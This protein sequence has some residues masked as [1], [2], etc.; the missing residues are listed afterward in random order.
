MNKKQAYNKLV[1]IAED[2]NP[3]LGGKAIWVKSNPPELSELWYMIGDANGENF[4]LKVAH[5]IIPH[6]AW[7]E[8]SEALQRIY[9][10][11]EIVGHSFDLD[12]Y[13]IGVKRLSTEDKAESEEIVQMY[14]SKEAYLLQLKAQINEDNI[15]EIAALVEIIPG[16][17]DDV[18]RELME[19]SV[20]EKITTLIYETS[21][22]A[23]KKAAMEF[24]TLSMKE[25][26]NIRDNCLDESRNAASYLNKLIP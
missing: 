8:I 21:I 1:S 20:Q 3:D 16:L 6:D 15:E 5:E 4:S 17:P 18:F 26:Q 14:Y 25:E 22:T 7:E 10:E 11:I 19:E 12:P 2:Y 13:Y 9:G 23:A 24:Y